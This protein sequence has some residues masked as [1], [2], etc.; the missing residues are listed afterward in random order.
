MSLQTISDNIKTKLNWSDIITAVSFNKKKDDINSLRQREWKIYSKAYNQFRVQLNAA[1]SSHTGGVLFVNLNDLGKA[2]KWPSFATDL[3][4]KPN[5]RLAELSCIDE[6][7]QSGEFVDERNLNGDLLGTISDP[8]VERY[9]IDLPGAGALHYLCEK[10]NRSNMTKEELVTIENQRLEDLGSRIALWCQQRRVFKMTV[11]YHCGCGAIQHRIKTFPLLSKSTDVLEVAKE[12]A[13]NTAIHIKL[14]AKKLDYELQVTTAFI[15][16]EQMCKCRPVEM[17]NAVGTM[18]CLDSRVLASRF[19]QITH[20]NFFDVFIMN[21]MRQSNSLFSSDFDY[22]NIAVA[23]I[24]LSIDI[25]FGK[26]GW[27]SDHFSKNQ[28]YLVVLFAKDKVQSDESLAIFD[29]L[30]KELN[31]DTAEKVKY[32]LVRTDL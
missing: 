9:I 22:R 27:G 24:K 3:L 19:D 28:P 25:V 23:N 8:R 29:K 32:Y 2:V 11:T 4:V 18:G 7:T 15:G 12:C 10:T 14:A 5:T 20:C 13:N 30:K 17:H 1:A 31:S 21:E 6:A 16:N 26:T